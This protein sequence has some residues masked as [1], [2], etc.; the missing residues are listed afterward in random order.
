[1]RIIFNMFFFIINFAKIQNQ[2]SM[3]TGSPQAGGD[4]IVTIDGMYQ[5]YFLDYA[6]YVILERAVPAIED[7]LKPVQRRILHSMYEAED[8]RYHK[9]A[10]MIGQTMQFHPHGD[11]AIGEAL[12]NLGQ[13]DLLIDTQGN[14]GDVRTGD[15]AA[16]PRYI[17]AR[18]TK[19]ALD[20]AF[21]PQTTKWQ[22]SYDGRKKE[23][24][25]LPMKFPILLAQGVE[26]IAVG[27]ATKILPHNFNEL[28]K[29]SIQILKGKKVEIFPDF[30]TGGSI[31]VADYQQGI[32]GG[33]V[34][35]RAK[36]EIVDKKTIAIR[37]LPYGITTGSLIE[38][39][40]KAADKGKIKVK[41]V[42]DNTARDVE[43]L[44]EL[45]P[46]VSPEVTVDALYAFTSC[47]LS[48]SPNACVIINDKPVFLKVNELLRINTENTK[49]LLLNELEIKK[50]E[51]LEKWHLTSL[52]KI[53][54]ENRIYRDIEECT[55]F[56]QVLSVID[57]GLKKYVLTPSMKATASDKRIKLNREISH[58]DLIHLTEI[59]IKKISKYNKFQTDETLKSLENELKK[60]KSD[61]DNI[62]D[63]T[64]AYYENL[65]TKY[66][67]G[68]ERKTKLME[69]E[70]I[71]ASQ[72]VANNSKLYVNREEGFVGY[73]LKKD[74]F[75]K[76]C[77]ELD[78]VIAFRGDAK[79][80][81]TRIS[82]KTFVGKD[83]KHVDV[84]KKADERTT[85]NMIYL[86]GETGR[87]MA[88][89]FN[90]TG[91]T[92]D[93][94]YDLSKG[95]PKS[96]TLYF[97][98]NPEAEAEIVSVFLTQ[99]CS[100]KIKQFDF[101]FA[102]LEIKSRSSMGN[103]VTKY[104]VRKIQLKEKGKS[105][106]G[107][108][109]VWYDE[110][111]GRLNSDGR[112]KFLGGLNK[113]DLLLI[114]YKNGFYEVSEYDINNRYSYEEVMEVSKYN[115]EVVISAVYFEGEKKW[116]MA[117]RFKVETSSYNQ[118]FQFITAHKDSKLY[119]ASA[120]ENPEV[121]FSYK[122]KSEKMEEILTLHEFVDVKGW[123]AIGNKIEAVS[124]LKVNAKDKKSSQ[125]GQLRVG[126]TLEFD[127]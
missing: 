38:S 124:L 65:L 6:S 79:F 13:K 37:E 26:G 51:I 78:D 32:R 123:K 117:K 9:V 69:F 64:I 29:A 81:V 90:V 125:S 47:E 67:K 49:Q 25:T 60:V 85:Y 63:F 2:H 59:K 89:R 110:A 52:E 103:I 94:E 7:G 104:P 111:S 96:K 118:R 99:G 27:L 18:L 19:F 83:L 86:D 102:E 75:I 53:F 46:G 8:G 36:I 14:W 10:N 21:N 56:E 127:L 3:N 74:E 71:Q 91:I 24:I 108:Q 45:Q 97:S 115:E 5:D 82:E 107:S 98:A 48:I 20:V 116:S 95:H 33:K 92:R 93:K 15:S 35:I 22:L 121:Y 76:D 120:E 68:R 50:A 41:T 16:A 17:E 119:W 113:G 66:G 57:I 101:N 61:I 11:S 58:D 88:K 72:V 87:A 126:D 43:I 34:K 122:M 44:I 100:A 31:D 109:Q 114:L 106:I 4:H 12:I 30:E 54:I 23:P 39:I 73:G 62:T 42:S 112:G 1:M 105:T 80:M 40:V 28:I 55:S 77:S 84:W 70:A